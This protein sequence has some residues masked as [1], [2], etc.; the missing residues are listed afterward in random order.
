[1]NC[2]DYTRKVKASCCRK[3]VTLRCILPLHGT[4]LHQL[5]D[6]PRREETAK[7]RHFMYS[8]GREEPV[9]TNKTPQ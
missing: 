1:M 6:F 4:G 8:E 3:M 7:H 9:S 5:Y 2:C